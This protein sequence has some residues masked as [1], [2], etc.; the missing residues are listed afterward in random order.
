MSGTYNDIRR[1]TE[2]EHKKFMRALKKLTF[3]EEEFIKEGP[4]IIQRKWEE[5]MKEMKEE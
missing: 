4:A 2:E 5:F 1:S 3:S